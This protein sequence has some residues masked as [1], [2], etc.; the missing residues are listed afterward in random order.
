MNPVLVAAACGLPVT[1]SVSTVAAATEMDDFMIAAAGETDLQRVKQKTLDLLSGGTG[2]GVHRI[3][4]LADLD[5]ALEHYHAQSPR[6]APAGSRTT[7]PV[8]V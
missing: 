6:Y 8:M 4:A 5:N 3:R 1:A 7:K 2:R